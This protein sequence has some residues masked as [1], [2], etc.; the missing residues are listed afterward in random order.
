MSYAAIIHDINLSFLITYQIVL[1]KVLCKKKNRYYG[2]DLI[3]FYFVLF[4]QEIYD[5]SWSSAH[6]T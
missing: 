4:H 3:D 6:Q 5:C 2:F 1:V